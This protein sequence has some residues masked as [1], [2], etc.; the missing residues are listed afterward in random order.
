MYKMIAIVALALVALVAV[1]L[2][3][4]PA[5]QT[6]AVRVDLDRWQELAISQIRP[7]WPTGIDHVLITRIPSPMGRSFTIGVAVNGISPCSGSGV[8]RQ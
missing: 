6:T 1:A 3:P 5:P 4:G 8:C 2:W 7:A